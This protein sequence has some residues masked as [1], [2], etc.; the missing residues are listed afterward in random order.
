M[1]I[2]YLL[3]D[4]DNT[5]YP[6]TS[7][8]DKGISIRMLEC[9]AEFFSVSIEQAEKLKKENIIHHSTT[10]EWMRSEG[11]TDIEGFLAHVHPENEADELQPQPGL[12]EYLLSLPYPKAIL[13][14][15]PKEHADR[16]LNKLQIADLFES[17]TDIRDAHFNGKPYEASYMAALKKTG[18]GIENTLFI[19]DMQKY[20]DGWA[21][22]G[23]TAVLVGNQN[24]KPLAKDAKALNGKTAKTGS[25]IKMESIYQLAE[26][27]KNNAECV[28]H[29]A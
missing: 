20:T 1:A 28:I 27:L 15:A 8:M 7:A 16:V 23:G 24:G 11:F 2:E 26:W 13:T 5:L 21:A 22:L 18:T 9:V 10:L 4:L 6:S 29:N 3:F 19:D 25:T 14:N 12:R 17:I